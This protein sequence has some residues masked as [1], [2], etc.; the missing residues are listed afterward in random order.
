MNIEQANNLL[1]WKNASYGE[2]RAI[3]RK[4]WRKYRKLHWPSGRLYI[5]KSRFDRKHG[6]QSG[7]VAVIIDG[8]GKEYFT[9]LTSVARFIGYLP[10]G[11]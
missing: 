7:E 4:E 1:V 9:S 3:I 5:M 10:E 8:A 6:C 2:K 11:D